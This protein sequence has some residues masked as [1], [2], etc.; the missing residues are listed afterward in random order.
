MKDLTII[1]VGR[2][3][4]RLKFALSVANTTI[5]DLENEIESLNAII[6]SLEDDI[7]GAQAAIQEQNEFIDEIPPQAYRRSRYHYDD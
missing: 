5:E 2:T 4:E 1:E 3:N 7:A 6:E